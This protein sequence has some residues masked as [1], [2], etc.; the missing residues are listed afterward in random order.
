MRGYRIELGEVEAGLRQHPEIRDVAVVA[1]NDRNGEKRLVAYVVGAYMAMT[2]LRSFLQNRLP[3]YMIPSA[4]MWLDELPLT[5][6]GKI[7]R[8]ALPM[9]ADAPVESGSEYEAPRTVTEELLAGIWS[10]VLKV[11]RVGIHDNFFELGGHSL[12]MAQ[13]MSRVRDSLQLEI[14]LR[15]LLAAP[16]ISE[17]AEAVEIAAREEQLDVEKIARLW[18][19]VEQLSP[20]ELEA[21]LSQEDSLIGAF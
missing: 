5:T 11:E 4:Y 8:K 15:T 9:P 3:D 20:V 7:D 14:P 18:L 21:A 13:V 16:T 2:E 6:N 1:Q 17:L 12:L 10:E 19:M